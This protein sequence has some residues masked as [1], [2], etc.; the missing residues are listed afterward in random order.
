M[1]IKNQILKT[2]NP[3]RILHIIKSFYI[4]ETKNILNKNDE[5]ILLN[6]DFLSFIGLE[7][8]TPYLMFCEIIERNKKIE[9]T[10]LLIKVINII[11]YDIEKR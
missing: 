4:V 1:T 7:E 6:L 8:K 10:E 2:I 9:S 11:K 5:F 3:V